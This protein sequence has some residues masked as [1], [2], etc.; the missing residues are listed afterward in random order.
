MPTEPDPPSSPPD[1]S[2][3]AAPATPD[4]PR[5]RPDLVFR[6]VA[7]DWLLFDPASGR[8]HV[9]NLTAALVWSFCT[10]ES[11][12][13]EIADALG[14]AFESGAESR[15]E[16]AVGEALERFRREGLLL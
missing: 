7:G 15:A 6:R 2:A 12:P 4:R 14:G 9:L 3:D 10:G 5:A 13:A 1:A 16:D 11:T 8:I